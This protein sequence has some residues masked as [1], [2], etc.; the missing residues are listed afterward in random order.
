MR[1]KVSLTPTGTNEWPLMLNSQ[2]HIRGGPLKGVSPRVKSYGD[3]H[4]KGTA[5]AT[6]R[7]CT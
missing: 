3:G 6:Y 5:P 1:F 7:R 2:A 4:T